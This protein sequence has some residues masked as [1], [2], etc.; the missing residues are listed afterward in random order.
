MRSVLHLGLDDLHHRLLR[1]VQAENYATTLDQ[2][3]DQLRG[4]HVA[5]QGLFVKYLLQ[6]VELG[7]L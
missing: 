4:L 6:L 1:R 7:K 2:L 5:G 3:G